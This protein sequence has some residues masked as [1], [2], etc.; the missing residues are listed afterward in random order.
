M[1]S[2]RVARIRDARETS[3]PVIAPV[4]TIFLLLCR[5][6]SKLIQITLK[7]AQTGPNTVPPPPPQPRV[8][9]YCLVCTPHHFVASWESGRK[10]SRKPW[11]DTKIAQNSK[12]LI[13]N[14]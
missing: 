9:K 7:S 2:V 10:L 5:N 11:Q 8:L 3:V 1:R 6:I 13:E 12:F 4:F 14:Y